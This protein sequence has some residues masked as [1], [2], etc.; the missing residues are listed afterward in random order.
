MS[1]NTPE[2]NFKGID[3]T[4]FDSVPTPTE[5]QREL[6]QLRRTIPSIEIPDQT[7][8]AIPTVQTQVEQKVVPHPPTPQV[9]S[10]IETPQNPSISIP[11]PPVSPPQNIQPSA[12]RS[13]SQ[14]F[15]LDSALAYMIKE[16]ASDLHLTVDAPPKIRLR[17]R[18]VPISD[19]KFT[20]ESISKALYKILNEERTQEFNKEQELD[21]A[22]EIQ[23]GRFRVNFF[24]QK[25]SPGAVFRHIDTNIKSL[26]ELKM[27]AQLEKFAE[28]PRGL[29][30]V[31]G[32]TGSGKSTT[33]AAILDLINRNRECHIMTIE[34][35]IEYVHQHKKA[36]INQRQVGTDTKNFASAL[37]HVLRQDPDVILVGELRDIETISIALTAA[38][39]GHLVLASLHTQDTAQSIDRIIDVFE[40]TQ[41]AQIRTMLAATLQ[42]VA[43][44]A[45]MPTVDGKGRVAATEIMFVN[46]AISNLI[47]EGKTHQIYSSLQGGKDVGMHTMDQSLA[48]LVNSK[49]IS[50]EVALEAVH[51]L[52]AFNLLVDSGLRIGS[53]NSDSKAWG[54]MSNVTFDRYSPPGKEG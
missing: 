38:E 46:S 34:D 22:Y 9:E 3:L 40:P 48:K 12:Q 14:N 54:E 4:E 21:F 8:R 29:V 36:N 7:E 32:P 37:K 10:R 20:E 1:H 45:L 26:E 24:Q 49:K 27:P 33:L 52:K 50:Y 19:V 5:S 51:D 17:G 2:P 42:A 41:Q 43:C 6:P 47:R 35:P 53:T 16:G 25:G 13:E 28:F 44:Q 30:L 23:N 31:T 11:S 18:L 39:T 15:D